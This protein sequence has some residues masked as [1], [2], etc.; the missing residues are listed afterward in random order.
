MQIQKRKTKIVATIGPASCSREVIKELL[1]EGMNVARLNFSH[2]T[3]EEHSE[4]AS[5]IREE[6]GKLGLQVAILQ[7]LCGPKIRISEFPE[8]RVKLEPNDRIELRHGDTPGSSNAL[9]VSAFDPAKVLKKGD[10][11]LLS[12]GQ[13]LLTT[14]EITKEAAVCSVTAGGELRSRSGIS[15]PDSTLNLAC[16][17][18]KDIK[19]LDWTVANRPDYV[20]LSFVS[21]GKD[22]RTLKEELSKR[23]CMTPVVSKFER[24]SSL[25]HLAEIIDASEA[26]MVARGD[27]GLEVPLE[28]VPLSQKQIINMANQHGKPVITATQM[29]SSMV[30]QV[31][32]T[33]AEVSDV[34]TAV[35]DGTDA[36]MLSEET[37]VGD[38]PPL[39][40]HMLS[41]IALEADRNKIISQQ[42]RR[43]RRSGASSVT[44]AVCY[45]AVS[46]ANRLS[47]S[48]VLAC[49]ESGH[50]ARMMSKYRPDQ[51][52][53]GATSNKVTLGKLCLY[54][55]VHPLL[56]NTNS[57]VDMEE[58]IV[59]AIDALRDGYKLKPGTRVVVTAGVKSKKAGSTSIM[60]VREVP[61][62]N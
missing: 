41:Q 42:D 43:T 22:V 59:S 48:A 27:L 53:F 13:I 8:G 4:T 54:W 21:C 20:A 56:I 15:V 58:E 60:Q 12:D 30:K 3:H 35:N 57:N 11:A 5:I 50:S 10:K 55:G 14:E 18:E 23:D 44:D 38:H 52:L 16:L 47:A 6:S 37:A 49:T 39:A 31:R 24:A 45:A 1:I 2:G 62:L 17:T 40:V 33:R 25:D 34:S 32:P 51:P 26:V 36:V 61:R 46:A 9:Y 19:D 29:L 28:R 7:D